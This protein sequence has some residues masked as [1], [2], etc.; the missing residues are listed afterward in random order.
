MAEQ[1]ITIFEPYPF[2]VGE[3]VRIVGG[4]R[5]GDWQVVGLDDRQVTLRCPVSGREFAWN[6]FCYLVREEVVASW[7]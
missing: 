4:K 7:P 3:K 6:R 1:K 5:R 2:V